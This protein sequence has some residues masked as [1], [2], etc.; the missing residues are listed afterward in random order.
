MLTTYLRASVAADA[1]HC[2]LIYCFATLIMLWLLKG[3][4]CCLQHFGLL[5]VSVVGPQQPA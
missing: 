4:L 3:G 5:Q 2:V 1:V